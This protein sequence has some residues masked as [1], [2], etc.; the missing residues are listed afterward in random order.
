MTL[1]AIFSMLE[2]GIN[3]MGSIDLLERSHMKRIA[4]RKFGTDGTCNEVKSIKKELV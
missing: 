3:C 2:T 1:E 4:S